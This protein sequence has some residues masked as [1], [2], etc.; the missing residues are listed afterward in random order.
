MTTREIADFNEVTTKTVRR[1]V[2][3]MS[4][5]AGHNVITSEKIKMLEAGEKGETVQWT[6]DEVYA[7]MTAGGRSSF[8]SW[9]RESKNKHPQNAEVSTDRLDRLE[10]LMDK[11]LVAMGNM[12]ILQQSDTTKPQERVMLPAP[13]LDPRAHVK[14]LIDQY[15]SRNQIEH[16]SAYRYLYSEFGYRTKCNPAL[17]A[18]NRGMNTIDY[19]ESEG[20][21][22]TLE[23]IA[24]E[25]L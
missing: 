13:Q 19:I 9:M 25:V 21:M 3:K 14:K 5:V 11:M 23:A 20:M 16:S 15:V 7:I 6:E 22:E 8:V 17:C 12:M 10:S 18:K 2:D 1:W 4:S 24:M